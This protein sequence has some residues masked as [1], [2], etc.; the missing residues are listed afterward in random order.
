M[1]CMRFVCENNLHGG[2]NQIISIHPDFKMFVLANWPGY[3]FLGNDFFR[4]IGD[5][6]AT[7]SFSFGEYDKVFL[8]IQLFSLLTHNNFTSLHSSLHYLIVT[9]KEKKGKGKMEKEFNDENETSNTKNSKGKGR[10]ASK[11][12]AAAASKSSRKGGR[13]IANWSWNMWGWGAWGLTDRK[14]WE[15]K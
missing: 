2:D 13:R 9:G 5:C 7:H 12:A 1:Y 14:T 15:C 6:L 3:P 11:V 4:E 10:L 8:L